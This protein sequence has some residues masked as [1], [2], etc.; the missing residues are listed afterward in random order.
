MIGHP[1]TCPDMIGG[2]EW[3]TKFLPGFQVDEEL[4]VRMAQ[5]SA[6]FPMMQFSWAPWQAL[7][8]DNVLLCKKAQDLHLSL[9]DDI[10]KLVKES[11]KS[12]EPVLRSLEYNDP[13]QGYAEI[14]D[15]F[16]LGNL[17]LSAPVVTPNTYARKVTFPKG[18]WMDEDGNIFEGR[19]EQVLEAPI[20]KL[21]W[22]RNVE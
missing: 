18:R 16:M 15:E 10:L 3:T 9:A 6:L 7:S 14:E 22:F 11:E 17:F 4:F 13:H 1:F 8:E 20:E 5:C 12:G 19:T 2:G 21:L